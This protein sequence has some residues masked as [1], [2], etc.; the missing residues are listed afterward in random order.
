LLKINLKEEEDEV[1]N[2]PTSVKTLEMDEK[3]K[4]YW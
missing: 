4:E 1:I 2:G 3:M